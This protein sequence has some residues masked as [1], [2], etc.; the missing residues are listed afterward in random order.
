MSSRPLH[1]GYSLGEAAM[2][3]ALG[4]WTHGDEAAR[5]LRESDLFKTRVAGPKLA[6]REAW[7][8][9]PSIPDEDLWR[10]YVLMAPVEQVASV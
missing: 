1:F 4:I 3:W 2:M 8:I 6:V 10:T 5:A 7:K 9:D